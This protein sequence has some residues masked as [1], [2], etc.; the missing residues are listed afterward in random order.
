MSYEPNA[1]DAWVP[2]VP[3]NTDAWTGLLSNDLELYESAVS[4]VALLRTVRLVGYA[5]S[6]YRVT[7]IIDTLRSILLIASRGGALLLP[8]P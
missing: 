7:T 4:V 6:P 3:G 5:T 1:P 8:L 2:P